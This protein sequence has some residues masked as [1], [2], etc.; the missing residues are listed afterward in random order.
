M[1]FSCAM[2]TP[3]FTQVLSEIQNVAS[4]VAERRGEL[5]QSLWLVSDWLDDRRDG[6][7]RFVDTAEL[8]DGWRLAVSPLAAPPPFRGA[9]FPLPLG[10]WGLAVVRGDEI[11]A[12]CDA[13]PGIAR[14]AVD[15]LPAFLCAYQRE[16]AQSLSEASLKQGRSL[17]ESIFAHATR[18]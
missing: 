13:A 6:L 2:E 15:R 10:R 14:L 16:L 11:R 8:A 3:A 4:R 12:A 5:A 7:V 17:S 18:T 9:D 1:L